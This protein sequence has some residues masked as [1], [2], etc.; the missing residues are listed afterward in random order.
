MY[1]YMKSS[2]VKLLVFRKLIWLKMFNGKD[3]TVSIPVTNLKQLPAAVNRI[4]I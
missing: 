3:Y 1:I 2:I 4:R